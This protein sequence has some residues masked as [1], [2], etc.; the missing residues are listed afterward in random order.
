MGE[1][2]G[3]WMA[4]VQEFDIDLKPAKLVKGQGL[5]K[6]TVNSQDLE[7]EYS[8]WQNEMALWCNEVAYIHPK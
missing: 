7:N 4:I 8:M 3:K 6:L 1:R 5:C 2:R